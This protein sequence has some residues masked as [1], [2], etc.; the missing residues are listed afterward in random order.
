VYARYLLERHSN[1]G[2]PLR[3]PE[4][5]STLPKNYQDY[6]LEIGDVGTVDSKG[7]FDVLFNIFKDG[8]N[9]LH[10]RHGVP[11]NFKPIAFREEDVKSI[12]NA[13]SSGPIYS[14]GI[15]RI[16]QRDEISPAKYE[17]DTSTPAGAL[18]ILPRDVTSFELSPSEQFREMAMHSALDWCN[19]AKQCYGGR[20]LDR[21][22]YLITGFYKSRSWSLASFDN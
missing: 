22:L 16:P 20:H 5:T 7:Q 15:K 19:F 1:Y 9:P 13:I 14:H 4:P 10:K 11:Q 8:K 12:D 17:F 21:S 6:G 3:I 18:L 2:Y